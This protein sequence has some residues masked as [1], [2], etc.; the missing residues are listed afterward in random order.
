MPP[1]ITRRAF[2]RTSALAPA[3]LAM[4]AE[5]SA[6]PKEG[7]GRPGGLPTMPDR[8][9]NF[10][11]IFCDNLGYGDIGCF[12]SELHRTPHVDRMAEEGMRFTD[13]YVTSGVCTPSRSSIMTACYPRRVNMHISD[14][15]ASVLQ[16]VSTKGLHADEITIAEVL[17]DAGYATAIVGKWHLGDQPQF[18]PT[19]QGF[20]YYLGIPYSDD[21]TPREGKP[22]PPLPLMENEKVIEAPV[23]RNL[24]TKRYT[25]ASIRFISENRERPFFLY[26]PHAM[27]GSTRAPF[28]SEAF[29]GKSRNGPWGDSVEEID[30]STGEILAAI[31]R[32]GLAE[33]TLVLWTSD[34]GAPL[35]NP[36]QG[37]N[38]PLSGSG[39]T[40][41]EGGMRVPTV[42]RWPGKVPAGAECAEVATTMDLMPTFAR[43]A[44][45]HVPTDRIIDG[46]DIWPLMSGEP[47]AR[48]PHEA[49]FYYH[50]DQLQAVR[51]GK[52]K[53]YLPLESKRGRGRA[54]GR[55]S[56][57]RLYDLAA[58]ISEKS[59]VV[60]DHPDVVE[61][62]NAFADRARAD[63]GDVDRPG[64]GQRPAGHEPNPTPR[65]LESD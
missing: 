29:R 32:L 40:T 47:G 59:N 18:L 42:L 7:S 38:L 20:D 15:G 45:A 28:A 43:L 27:P 22:W 56:P 26:L 4:R 10:I 13:F 2:I 23:D 12:G 21:M 11:I 37:S 48:S 58:D 17:K 63:L 41:A 16:P 35:R 6:Q 51:S 5:A 62:L 50:M 1:V 61:R 64:S 36:P 14:T 52:W 33:S 9:P 65:V 46:K 39:Y 24:L 8:P 30:W 31:E 49:F 53:L 54:A 19:R 25:E 34:N 60:E 55:P 57:A 44:G 3:A